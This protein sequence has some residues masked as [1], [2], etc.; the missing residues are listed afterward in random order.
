MA[1]KSR[2]P[3]WGSSLA[4][5]LSESIV[6]ST[7]LPGKRARTPKTAAE[8]ILYPLDAVYERA[9]VSLPKAVAISPYAVPL[10]YRSLL[11]HESDMTM[12][13]EQHFGGRLA[14]RVLSTFETP[15]GTSAACCSS[16]ST[17]AVRCRWAPSGWTSTPSAS[18]SARQILRNQMPLGRL[19][20]DH[21]VD[22]KSQPQVFLSVTPNS[23]MMGVFWMREPRTLYGR[24]THMLTIAAARS[25]TSS[26]S[27]PPV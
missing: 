6:N 3:W 18:V 26:R 23:E 12:V 20:R 22:F 13:L 8:S 4:T 27:C 5:P 1:P 2:P 24:K 16:R 11:V 19:L 9:G 17:P 10:P 25:A 14:L 15:A 21:G 7:K